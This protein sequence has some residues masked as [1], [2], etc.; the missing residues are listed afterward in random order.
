MKQWPDLLQ[1]K[2]NRID[3]WI[4]IEAADKNYRV[5]RGCNPR[6]TEII[7]VNTVWNCECI[8]MRCNGTEAFRIEIRARDVGYKIVSDSRLI[9]AHA[10]TLLVKIQS[11]Q[12][13]VLVLRATMQNLGFHVVM[14]QCRGRIAE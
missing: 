6:R 14:P 9:A 2:Q 11:L 4:P 10:P 3:V 5:A 1:E 8:D 12:P 13:I 7:H